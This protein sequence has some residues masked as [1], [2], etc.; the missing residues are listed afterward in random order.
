MT[1]GLP[2]YVKRFSSFPREQDVEQYVGNVSQGGD[3]N[4]GNHSGSKTELMD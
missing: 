1:L 2:V 3:W 4:P